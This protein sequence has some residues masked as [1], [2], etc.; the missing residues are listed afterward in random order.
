V[1]V[2]HDPL[3]PR[4]CAGDASTV[5]TSAKRRSDLS[6]V[7]RVSA[8]NGE[9]GYRLGKVA[10]GSP[11]DEADQVPAI[12]GSPALDRIALSWLVKPFDEDEDHGRARPHL[13]RFLP[14][15]ALR[16]DRTTDQ[17]QQEDCESSSHRLHLLGIPVHKQNVATPH[18]H[19]TQR[20]PSHTSTQIVS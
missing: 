20:S 5:R 6:G 3:C 7:T 4:Q 19:S 15:P 14:R 11:A 18:H 12:L 2:A 1:E 16:S 10:C 13:T 9:N 8:G 17:R